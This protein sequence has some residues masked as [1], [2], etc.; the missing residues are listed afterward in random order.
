MS[1][2]LVTLSPITG[3]VRPAL[4]VIRALV[5]AGH[6]VLVYTGSK[7]ADA[8]ADAG[9]TVAHMVRGR[10]VDDARLDAWSQAQGHRPPGCAGCSGT[11]GTCSSI[12]SPTTWTI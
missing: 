8:V 12:R 3:H 7:F 4:P 9:G 6:D 5:D 1:R 11:C 10:D 2:I